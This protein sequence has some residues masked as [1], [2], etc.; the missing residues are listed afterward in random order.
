M[1]LNSAASRE[2]VQLRTATDHDL[3]LLFKIYASTREEELKL[4]PWDQN[5]L[6]QFLTMQFNAQHRFYRQTFPNATFDIVVSDRTDCGRMYVHRA[7]DEIR[8]IDIALLPRYQNVGIGSFLISRILNEANGS[9]RVVRIHVEKTNRALRL[10]ERLGFGR[11]EDEQIYW[12]MEYTPA[13][14]GP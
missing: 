4:A 13:R 10:Y 12:L 3:D 14:K 11:I 7:V 8:I 6:A 9:Q 2:N 5:Q 1:N